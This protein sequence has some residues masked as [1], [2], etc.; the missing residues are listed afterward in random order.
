MDVMVAR[1]ILRERFHRKTFASY[2]IAG[3]LAFWAYYGLK[4]LATVLSLI[5]ADIFSKPD[6]TWGIFLS[7]LLMG[8]F[9]GLM[10]HLVENILILSVFPKIISTK[11]KIFLKK[12]FTPLVVFLFFWGI[13]SSLPIKL[14]LCYATIASV[15]IFACLRIYDLIHHFFP[16]NSEKGP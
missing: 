9:D 4:T 6:F 10:V 14:S 12:A 2:I 16:I 11:T 3:I 15:R 5:S 7:T 1:N 8:I 13:T